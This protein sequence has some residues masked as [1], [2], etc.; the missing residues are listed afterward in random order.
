MKSIQSVLARSTATVDPDI[1]LWCHNIFHA[2]ASLA[3]PVE[4][5]AARPLFKDGDKTF[6]FSDN[7]MNRGMLAVMKEAR[8]RGLDES[9]RMAVSWRI[10]HFGDL[11]KHQGR[12]A[13]FIRPGDSP[14]ELE[15]SE[16]LIR[17]C[18][19]AKVIV[20]K[21][22]AQFDVADVIRIASALTAAENQPPP[23][24]TE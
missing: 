17:A 9:Q 23:A 22:D 20:T 6:A 13:A 4:S 14:G 21:K 12:L 11:I 1:F 19:T 18:A 3:M 2:A 15:I 10:M 5:P 16:A 7:P 8:E 24:G